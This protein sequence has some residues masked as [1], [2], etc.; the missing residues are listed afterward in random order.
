MA[1]HNHT[2]NAHN[3]AITD[4]GHTHNIKLKDNF[5]VTTVVG[6]SFTTG[7][8]VGNQ[9]TDTNTTGISVDSNTATNNATGGDLPH[10]NMQPF[11]GLL[12]IIKT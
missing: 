4:P 8:T 3:H 2:Q 7:T 12:Y 9:F 1:S 11:V 5:G 10:N 6:Y